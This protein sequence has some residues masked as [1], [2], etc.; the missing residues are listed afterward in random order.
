MWKYKNNNL[1]VLYLTTFLSGTNLDFSLAT[2]PA[3]G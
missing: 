2:I 1:E 3:F